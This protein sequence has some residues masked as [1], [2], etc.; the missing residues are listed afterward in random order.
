MRSIKPNIHFFLRRLH[1]LLGL[2]P[3]GGFLL[4]HL[5]ENS[6]SRFG[7]EHYNEQVVAVLQETN[8]I[9][10]LEIF[11]VAL[12]I[13]FHAGYGLVILGSG[14]AELRRYPWLR[15]YFYW[16]QRISGI[17][18]LFFLLLH[19]GMTRI[20]GLW[21]PSI[22]EDLYT[23]MHQLL[24][25]PILLLFY[26]LGLLLSVFHLGNGLWSMGITWGVTV[27]VRAQQLSSRFCMALSS[28]LMAL[29]IH[30]IWGFMA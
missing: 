1:S 24:S 19:V 5:W 30:G 4:F 18:I 15:N 21:E 23:H 22:K 10:F 20:W 7:L 28:L 16:L 6:Q 11:F 29:G 2:L 27:S 8:Y 14:N 26:L 17:G 3:I 13:L 12:P 25:N 9:L